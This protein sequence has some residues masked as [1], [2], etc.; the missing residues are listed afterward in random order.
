M[1][2]LS[3]PDAAQREAAA[4]PGPMMVVGPGSAEEHFV[5]HRVRETEA[6]TPPA[7]P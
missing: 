6:I 2:S 1:A 3:C 4:R 7:L 5:L